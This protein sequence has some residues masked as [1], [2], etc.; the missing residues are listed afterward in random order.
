[1]IPVAGGAPDEE[2]YR[3]GGLLLDQP[4]VGRDQ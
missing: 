4:G 3:I 1:M 2:L